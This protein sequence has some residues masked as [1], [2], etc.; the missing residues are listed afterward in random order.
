MTREKALNNAVKLPINLY[1]C[2][3]F[4][5][6]QITYIV[7]KDILWGNFIFW[8][9]QTAKMLKHLLDVATWSQNFLVGKDKPHMLDVGSNDCTFLKYF[10]SECRVLGVDP[11]KEIARHPNN[12]GVLTICEFFDRDFAN[13][14]IENH[15]K[16]ASLPCL[17]A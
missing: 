11:A 16:F 7:E 5:H 13:Q 3:K 8:S 17:N 14:M 12:D 15:G 6:T 9:G 1:V 10:P 4:F 2:E